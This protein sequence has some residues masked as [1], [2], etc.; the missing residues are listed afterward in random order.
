[1][2]ITVTDHGQGRR[3]LGRMPA[4]LLVLCMLLLGMTTMPTPA[5]A[6]AIP[7]GAALWFACTEQTFDGPWALRCPVPYSPEYEQTFLNGFQRFTPENEFKMVYT[8]PQQNKF[9]F[10]VAD[11]VAAFAQ[12]HHRTIRGHTLLWNQENPWWLSH[13]LLGWT[14]NALI[15]VMHSYISTVV[16]HFAHAFPGVVTEWDVVNEPLNGDGTIAWSPWEYFIGPDYIP[17]A[18]EYA[19][20]AD[21][22]ARLVINDDD[23]DVPGTPKAEAE[24]ALATSLKQS[25]V[26]LDAV[27]F[28]S[29][30]MPS[31]APSYADLVSLWRRY[32]AAGLDVEITELDVNNDH[33]VDDPAAKQAIFDRYARACRAVG[34]C[35]GMTVWGVADQ[36][37]W[38]GANTDALLYNTA[39][40]ATPAVSV[41]HGFLAG[42]TPRRAGPVGHRSRHRHRHRRTRLRAS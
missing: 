26:P 16:G 30:V 20:A 3:R 24:L 9:D 29:H 33:G 23:N 17:L 11:E 5:R 22:S 31:T 2:G 41:V 35:V 15:G 14:R 18:L 39:F 37:S 38:L 40:A 13:Q 21:P 25:G 32:K 36:Y 27:G 1:M 10:R 34:N 28:E 6:A 42:V 12:A 7:E 8:E 19:H 4:V